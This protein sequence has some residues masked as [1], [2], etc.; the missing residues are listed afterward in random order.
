MKKSLF[1]LFIAVAASTV[2]ATNNSPEAKP[3]VVVNK[4]GDARSSTVVVNRSSNKQA[5][6]QA[7][8]QR[9]KQNQ[10]QKQQQNQLQH[11]STGD[12]TMNGSNNA[13]VNVVTNNPRQVSSAANVTVMPTAVCS[14]TTAG[15]AQGA[16][17]GVSFGTSW[18]DENCM[19]LEQVRMVALL[20]ESD[21]ASEMMCG[22]PAYREARARAGNACTVF[23][24]AKEQ[25]AC[26][27]YKGSDPIVRGR[28]CKE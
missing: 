17:F 18:T 13:D 23:L 20:G 28:V 26:E 11:Q 27:A 14:G 3:N 16:A 25:P 2:F 24:A 8:K 15:G 4:G 10:K 21:I 5:Q 7:Q 6:A 12:Q 19:L 9:Q 22:V 1:A